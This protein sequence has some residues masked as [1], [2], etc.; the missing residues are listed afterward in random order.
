MNA[1]AGAAGAGAGAFLVR[2]FAAG[3]APALHAAVRASLASL[4]DWVPWCRADYALADAQQR[5]DACIAA[6]RE[7][8]EYPF[9]IFDGDTLLGCAGLNQ[10]DRVAGSANLGYWVG[11]A[12]RGRGVATA[13]AA[14]VAAFGFGELG[15]VRIEIRVLPE[16]AAS[17]G[18]ARRLGAV[19]EA[20]LPGGIEFQ[21]RRADAVLFSLSA[22]DQA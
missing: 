19:R 8:R 16:N 17:L 12:H 15:L 20:V 3:D 18:V 21:G 2:P 5:S 13:A 11:E 6:W 14:Q 7:D 10:L 22:G 9:A 4:S 1:G